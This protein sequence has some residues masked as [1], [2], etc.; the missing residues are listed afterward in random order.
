[1]RIFG[2]NLPVKVDW[3]PYL[4][5]IKNQGHCGS[6]TAF[7]TIGVW[8]GLIKIFYQKEIDLSE[9]DLL[10]CSGGSCEYGNQMPPVL[11]RT[12]VGVCLEE[13]CPYLAVTTF[14]GQGRCDNWWENGWKTKEWKQITDVTE[15]KK[16][17][18]NGPLVG[19]MAVH[20]SFLHYKEGVYHSLGDSD[21]IVGY[22]CIG[23]VGYDD[24]KQAWLLRNSWGIEWGMKG[25]CWIKYG[26]SEIDEVMYKLIP[27]TEKPE[28]QPSPSPCKY[29]RGI[30]K[31]LNFWVW[32]LHRKG[33][34]YY[35]NPPRRKNNANCFH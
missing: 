2:S 34:F 27:T 25:Y 24:E 30:A 18:C 6:C 22:H 14:C 12:T 9:Q 29:G 7:G 33:R 31:F 16:E 5:P 19:V 8:E 3:R 23:I 26:D 20:E 4:T 21:Q 11:D 17:L 10:A 15:M 13:C 1:M 35:L 28:P 32:L